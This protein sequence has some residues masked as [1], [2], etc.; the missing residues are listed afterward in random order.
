MTITPVGS[1]NARGGAAPGQ[2]VTLK[3]IPE[4]QEQIV[5]FKDE[6]R[7]G[8]LVFESNCLGGNYITGKSILH[9][10]RGGE[11]LTGGKGAPINTP[12]WLLSDQLQG[13][14]SDAR[15]DLTGS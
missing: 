14:Q 9:T 7:V 8:S 2:A 15:D 3:A 1:F 11:K 13:L 6:Y 4:P 12:T 5:S 10:Q